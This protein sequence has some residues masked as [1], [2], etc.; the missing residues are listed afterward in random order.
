MQSA[1]CVTSA[2]VVCI[3]LWSLYFLYSKIIRWWAPSA[4][5]TLLNIR[6]GQ[7][8]L[9]VS[10]NPFVCCI[11]HMQIKLKT[12]FGIFQLE[13]IE[14]AKR[15]AIWSLF[16]QSIISYLKATTLQSPSGKD[17]HFP[18]TIN[19]DGRLGSGQCKISK[20]LSVRSWG[21]KW[22]NRQKQKDRKP[23]WRTYFG[24]LSRKGG[25]GFG[26]GRGEECVPVVRRTHLLSLPGWNEKKRNG[27]RNEEKS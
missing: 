17:G 14:R 21:G 1:A 20:Q 9:N 8:R 6:P 2:V 10:L 19:S 13:S 4:T 7:K 3:T 16:L 24:A 25:V 22:R 27:R 26:R 23:R 11:S 5:K 15:D 18:W 12:N